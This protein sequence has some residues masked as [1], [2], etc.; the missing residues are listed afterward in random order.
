MP[1]LEDLFGQ[2]E[3]AVRLDW[4]P[5]GAQSSGAD[6]AVVV[7]VLSF[8]TSVCVA[9]ERGMSVFPYQW[10]GPGAEAFAREREAVLAVG[11]L[12]SSL[13]DSPSAI[14]LSPAALLAGP[15]VP[16]LVLPSP[17]GSTITTL[18]AGSGAHVVV[19][20][21]RN[22]TA[23]ADLIAAKLGRG[24]TVA[25][26]AAGERWREDGSPRPAL[27]DHLGAGAV[28]SALS[29]LGHRNAMSPEASAAAGL[30]DVVRPSLNQY[31]HD[32]V[33]ARELEA[34]GFRS[35]VDV[36]ALLDV[37]PLVPVLIDGAF[38]STSKGEQPRTARS[39]DRAMRRCDTRGWYVRRRGRVPVQLL[40][41]GMTNS[42]AS[43]E[44]PG[45]SNDL[46][47]PAAE[48]SARLGLSEW[49]RHVC[50]ASMPGG[51]SA[52]HPRPPWRNGW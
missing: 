49:R 46:A 13:P 39:W 38:Q 41:P 45:N 4:G 3:Y 14:S 1:E 16:R 51:A 47:L 34:M 44:R 37:S 19:G 21:L 23:V 9:V 5:V 7:D 27:E 30:F 20:C 29:G 17:N 6:V 50:E 35:D 2:R 43:L 11:R 52:G 40:G 28:L 36:A 32:C 42:L 48:D 25:V 8:S 10:K 31:M 15:T 33:G 26:I 22:A 18:L 24:D 12:E